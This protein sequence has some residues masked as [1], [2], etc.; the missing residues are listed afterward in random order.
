MDDEFP[1]RVA[2]AQAWAVHLS[3]HKDV[4]AADSRR[5]SL[6]RYLRGKW[7]AGESDPD[8]LTCYGLSYLARLRSESW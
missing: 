6:E 5:C 8:E 7:Q 3:A 1:L 4:N 2:V